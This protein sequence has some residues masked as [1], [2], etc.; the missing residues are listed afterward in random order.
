MGF[1]SLCFAVP[2]DPDELNATGLCVC[3]PSRISA[4]VS[5]LSTCSIYFRK[6]TFDPVAFLATRG[7][8]RQTELSGLKARGSWRHR[9]EKRSTTRG[10]CE[11]TLRWFHCSSKFEPTGC[12]KSVAPSLTSV[13][14][15]S[16]RFV[17]RANHRC[18]LCYTLMSVLF[19][20]VHV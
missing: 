17:K 1:V 15:G 5:V 11:T 9:G 3:C 19:F 7:N 4:Y 10:Y 8:Y 18:P 2:C 16:M 12:S 14:R 6:H 13:T 20:A